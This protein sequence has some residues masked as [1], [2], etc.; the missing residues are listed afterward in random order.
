MTQT[1]PGPRAVSL[2]SAFSAQALLSYF[3]S[4]QGPL[5]PV[6]HRSSSPGLS[7]AQLCCSRCGVLFTQ[8]PVEDH[9]TTAEGW[10]SGLLGEARGQAWFGTAREKSLWDCRGSP[11]RAVGR[12]GRSEHKSHHFNPT[13]TS[14]LRTECP[15][16]VKDVWGSGV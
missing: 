4:L 2:L 11:C 1:P 6:S 13:A 16:L 10:E 12:G 14:P 15:W 8:S 9:L 3:P 5:L 7:S